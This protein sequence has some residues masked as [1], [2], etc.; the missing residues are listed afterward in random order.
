MNASSRDGDT[1]VKLV[2]GLGNPGPEYAAS[3]HNAG[4]M[5][6]ERL[7]ESFPEGRFVEYRTA[8]SRLY[9]G[10]FR[11]RP[12]YLQQPL[13]FMNLSGEAVAKA[14]GRLQL[15]PSEILVVS[16]DL[17]LPL[18]RLRLRRGGSDGG[19]NG[20]KSVISELG[21]ADVRRLRL[22]IGRPEHKG[23]VVDYV[24]GGFAPGEKERFDACIEA[25]VKAVKAVLSM[26]FQL[27]MNEVN[28][29]EVEPAEAK[30]TESKT[31][32]KKEVLL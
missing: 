14:A 32:V 13:T 18:G 1:T 5:V 24:L 23:E 8:S 2:V 26:P 7:L 17:E 16:D 30:I 15:E 9:A 28:R 10:R 4:F 25:A 3:R 31:T 20:L 29:R 6:I 19:H 27:A 22:G 11:R 21:S 12:L